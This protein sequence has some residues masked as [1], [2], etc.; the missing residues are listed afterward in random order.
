MTWICPTCSHEMIRLSADEFLCNCGTKVIQLTIDSVG[1]TYE[2]V[3]D[4]KTQN[5]G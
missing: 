1:G 4:D 5:E 3:E 2:P